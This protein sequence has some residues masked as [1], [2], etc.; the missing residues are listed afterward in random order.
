MNKEEMVHLG[1]NTYI[2]KVEYE[3]LLK[4]HGPIKISDKSLLD[5]HLIF[6]S[7]RGK[8]NFCRACHNLENGIKTRKSVD[9]TCGKSTKEIIV[10]IES[11]KNDS[12]TK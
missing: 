3:K 12:R 7:S 5:G 6:V 2:S 1:D 11:L 10:F 9:H 8:K 4:K